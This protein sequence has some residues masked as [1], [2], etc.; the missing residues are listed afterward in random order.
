MSLQEWVSNSKLFNFMHNTA[1]PATQIL[2]GLEWDLRLDQL[3]SPRP[4]SFSRSK[5]KVNEM[6]NNDNNNNSWTF[7]CSERLFFQTF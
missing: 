5:R 7:I 4:V 3:Q 2:L 6:N 1:P